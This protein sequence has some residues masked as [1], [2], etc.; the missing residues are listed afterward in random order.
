MV[1]LILTGLTAFVVLIGAQAR[2]KAR[3]NNCLSN[4]KQLAHAAAMYAADYGGRYP[5]DSFANGLMPYIKN[6][7]VLRCPT[8]GVWR[9]SFDTQAELREAGENF[10]WYRDEQGK[11]TVI[12]YYFVPGLCSDDRPDTILAYDDIPDRHPHKSFNMVRLDGAGWKLPAGRWPG[13][14]AQVKE[15]AGNE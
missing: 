9:G 6:E 15:V 4:L 3:E 2:S 10:S 11:L 13:V 14:P 8:Q 12:D 1:M 7:Q 5:R